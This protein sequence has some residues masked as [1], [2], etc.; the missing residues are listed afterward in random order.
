[1]LDSNDWSHEGA[2]LVMARWDSRQERRVDW[3]L[4]SKAAVRL[5]RVRIL[6]RPES[7]ERGGFVF[8]FEKS[9]FN[10]VL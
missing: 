8:D 5:S 6:R 10:A 1:M 2:V 3:L 4:V 7:V 9:Y